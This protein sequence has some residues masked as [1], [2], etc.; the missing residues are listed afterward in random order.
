MVNPRVIM[1][2]SQEM[3]IEEKEDSEGEDDSAMKEQVNQ[4]FAEL[5]FDQLRQKK[6]IRSDGI[7]VSSQKVE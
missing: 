1:A 5:N 3:D 4:F 7:K 2:A 6:R